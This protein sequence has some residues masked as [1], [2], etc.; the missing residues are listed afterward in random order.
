MSKAASFSAILFGVVTIVAG[1]RVLLG[2]NPGYDVY[3]P[4]L[5]FNTIMGAVYVLVGIISLKK[6]RVGIHGAA[7][8]CLLNFSVLGMLLYMYA[9]N[10]VVAEASV[11]AM[12][13][14][15]VV[16]VALFAILAATNRARLQR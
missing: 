6:R 2:E 1:A 5:Y 13:F 8:I 4:L 15:T 16:W 7:I 10:G 9:P 12:T 14:R 3:F 11:Q